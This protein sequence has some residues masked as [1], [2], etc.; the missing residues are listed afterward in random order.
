LL[1]GRRRSAPSLGC[2]RL[3]H[4]VG[5]RGDLWVVSQKFDHSFGLEAR[6]SVSVC[7]GDDAEEEVDL[8]R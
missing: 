8:T 3:C 7:G 6:L 4:D 5:R 1:G 2:R